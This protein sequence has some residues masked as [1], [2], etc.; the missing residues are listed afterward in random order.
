M[1]WKTSSFCAPGITGWCMRA[2]GSWSRP[3]TAKSS[4]SRRLPH[5]WGSHRRRRGMGPSLRSDDRQL[6]PAQAPLI[7]FVQRMKAASLAQYL[8]RDPVVTAPAE[9]W[10]SG[11]VQAPKQ[12]A[13]AF[14]RPARP[15]PVFE[16]MHD[17]RRRQRD[18]L[19]AGSVG[20]HERE[21]VEVEGVHGP[22]GVAM[23][24]LPYLISGEGEIAAAPRKKVGQRAAMRRVPHCSVEARAGTRVPG[25]A[26]PIRDRKSTR[27]NSSH[28]SISYA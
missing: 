21:A 20:H 10:D 27:L 23:H 15:G 1:S 25:L 14:G 8:A 5:S 4:P 9:V 26:P 3:T 19:H 2:G 18:H 13:R 17:L 11:R 12:T 22:F 28:V 6:L 24:P 7:T 16:V